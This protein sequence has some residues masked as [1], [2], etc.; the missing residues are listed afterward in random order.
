MDYLSG[1]NM[2]IPCTYAR[3]TADLP[4]YYIRSS[5]PQWKCS[6]C[7]FHISPPMKLQVTGVHLWPT[8]GHIDPSKIHKCWPFLVI[9][10]SRL[11]FQII[12]LGGKKIN[13]GVNSLFVCSHTWL[14]FVWC[15]GPCPKSI[16]TPTWLYKKKSMMDRAPTG[17]IG[18]WLLF[19]SK[20]TPDW[21]QL[22]FDDIEKIYDL[23]YCK[24]LY[25]IDIDCYVHNGCDIQA[26]KP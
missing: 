26:T 25:D 6:H 7:Q 8:Q 21:C 20:K 18:V 16:Q 10:L 1:L 3:S 5:P 22:G 19:F 23:R 24:S 11:P 2:G 15:D 4:Q 12:C 9:E 13:E 17:L 14:L